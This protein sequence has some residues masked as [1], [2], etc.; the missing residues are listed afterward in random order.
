MWSHTIAKWITRLKNKKRR[1]KCIV[2]SSLTFKCSS[3]R[4]KADSWIL[5]GLI[6]LQRIFRHKYQISAQ[7]KK[8]KFSSQNLSLSQTSW[9]LSTLNVAAQK[10]FIITSLWSVHM[11]LYGSNML[12]TALTFLSTT[13]ARK[14]CTNVCQIKKKLQMRNRLQSISSERFLKS[15]IFV[16]MKE[17]QWWL[18]Y[19][20]QSRS[21]LQVLVTHR[22]WTTSQAVFYSI[23][24]KYSRLSWFCVH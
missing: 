7:S 8:S 20:T 23:P 3:K 21:I 18:G 12:K 16:P 9:L 10:I 15:H 4:H 5:L 6:A 2:I 19:S 22:E 17:R 24:T 13:N 14:R 11:S 1:V